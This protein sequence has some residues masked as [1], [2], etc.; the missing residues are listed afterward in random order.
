MGW[1]LGLRGAVDNRPLSLEGS[2]PSRIQKLTNHSH[3][4]KTIAAISRK[5]KER[6][7]VGYQHYVGQPGRASWTK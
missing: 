3:K 4:G 2:D 6:Y 1:V 5:A 7:V